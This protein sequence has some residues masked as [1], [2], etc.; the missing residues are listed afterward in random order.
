MWLG[1]N[2]CK[3]REM[4]LNLDLLRNMD[5]YRFGGAEG[6][7]GRPRCCWRPDSY[8]SACEKYQGG[9][10]KIKT[11]ADQS[12]HDARREY[13][14]GLGNQQVKRLL[15]LD[16]HGHLTPYNH[17]P[18]PPIFPVL[19]SLSTASQGGASGGEEGVTAG[20]VEV[21]SWPTTYTNRYPPTPPSH[22]S[23][24]PLNSAQPP[25][26][27]SGSA[28]VSLAGLNTVKML[29]D[30]LSLSYHSIHVNHL[31]QHRHSISMLHPY[32]WI[33]PTCSLIIKDSALSLD[34]GSPVV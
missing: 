6:E 29:D 11:G 12:Q 25:N 15:F 17:T 33:P 34:N 24:P 2:K 30:N 8:R 23:I 1:G 9:C 10:G 31:H 4:D 28:K 14:Q 3:L 18:A 13:C 22:P 21:V 27:K 16:E 7:G 20:P 19:S 32:D 26:Y 5:M